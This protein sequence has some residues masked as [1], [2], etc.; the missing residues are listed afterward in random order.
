M[1]LHM[2]AHVCHQLSA[3]T[4]IVSAVG[5]VMFLSDLASARSPKLSIALKRDS[6]RSMRQNEIA[7]RIFELLT[8]PK[9]TKRRPGS[10]RGQR[11]LTANCYNIRSV[12]RSPFLRLTKNFLFP[13]FLTHANTRLPKQGNILSLQERRFVL[14]STIARSSNKTIHLPLTVCSEI[15]S[16]FN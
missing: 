5:P 3:Q 7:R 13:S 2:L 9:R 16:R 8:E 15:R 10:W 1:C 6:R 14:R 11:M 4:S 12:L